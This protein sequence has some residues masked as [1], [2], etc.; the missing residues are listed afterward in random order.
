LSLFIAHPPLPPAHQLFPYTTLFR[1]RAG[2]G[3][4]VM[5][6]DVARR[7][8]IAA[9]SA[10]HQA[11]GI[12]LLRQ[13]QNSHRIKLAPA[14]VERHPDHN[15]RVIVTAVDQ[16]P[17]FALVN[18][19]GLRRAFHLPAV[20]PAGPAPFGTLVAAGHV[21]PDQQPELVAP[22]VP[23]V[24][25]HLHMLAGHVEPEL[26]QHLDVGTQRL[27]R[28]RR[29]KTVR[30]EALVERAKHETWFVVQLNAEAALGVACQRDFS[31]AEITSDLVHDSSASFKCELAIA[32]VW[33]A[34]RPSLWVLDAE[35]EGG[36]VASAG[37]ASFVAS[38]V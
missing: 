20:H 14:L 6:K 35:V 38:V 34:G 17:E 23:A 22:V 15:A 2:P 3:I 9:A 16:R 29:V 18:P 13:V 1:S 12:E 4:L 25:L 26:L 36:R 21:L 11:R 5:V 24:R 27:I 19:R 32:E 33:L 10:I 8:M 31:Q 7:E 28:R 37:S 30:P